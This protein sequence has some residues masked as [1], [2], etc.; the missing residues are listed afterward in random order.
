MSNWGPGVAAFADSVVLAAVHQFQ[1][2]AASR[3]D[4]LCRS[5]VD[6][7]AA[8][9]LGKGAD[10][11]V[12]HVLAAITVVARHGFNHILA[13]LLQWRTSALAGP[14][15]DVLP[16]RRA[17]A[18]DFIFARA[19]LMV[20]D[21]M[22]LDTALLDNDSDVELTDHIVAHPIDNVS[23]LVDLLLS[24]LHFCGVFFDTPPV[25]TAEVEEAQLAV[26]FA[27]LIGK[28]SAWRE[29]EI[30]TKV[31]SIPGPS[32]AL[33]AGIRFIRLDV[34]TAA[35]LQRTRAFLLDFASAA[36]ASDDT[37]LAS[38]T[39][40]ALVDLVSPLPACIDRGAALR[41]DSSGLDE[42]TIAF[43]PVLAS[44]AAAPAVPGTPA[45]V[46]ASRA[47]AASVQVLAVSSPQLFMDKV[48]LLIA[49]LAA[50]ARQRTSAASAL[51]G[52]AQLAWLSTALDALLEALLD[53]RVH[54]VVDDASHG[55]P[56]SDAVTLLV[57]L[58][59]ARRDWLLGSVLGETLLAPSASP[60]HALVG[61][62]TLRALL[63]PKSP[64]LG[65][66]YPSDRAAS[67]SATE[68]VT[69]VGTLAATTR[70]PTYPSLV[71]AQD[72]DAL[73]WL[74]ST[75]AAALDS[76]S[77][78]TSSPAYLLALLDALPPLLTH[79]PELIASVPQLP[80]FVISLLDAPTSAVAV[81]A[82]DM[83]ASL[84]E[85]QPSLR[86]PIFAAL[87]AAAD[88]SLVLDR[89]LPPAS[90]I[91]A[92]GASVAAWLRGLAEEATW[93]FDCPNSG[94]H[95]SDDSFEAAR[96]HARMD[97]HTPEALG[98]LLLCSPIA[99]NR[100][101]GLDMLHA[102]RELHNALFASFDN[103]LSDDDGPAGNLFGAASMKM[104]F[105]DVIDEL[106]SVLVARA[107]PAAPAAAPAAVPLS[108]PSVALSS[109]SVD[110][111]LNS[112]F[113]MPTEP[114]PSALGLSHFVLHGAGPA[115]AIHTTL[116]S[117][118]DA[119]LKRNTEGASLRSAAPATTFSHLIEARDS[120]AQAQWTL[121][122]GQLASTAVEL[123]PGLVDDIWAAIA[124][125]LPFVVAHL[126]SP[127]VGA[128]PASAAIVGL[129]RNFLMFAS[130]AGHAVPLVWA[131]GT[132]QPLLALEDTPFTDLS[133]APSFAIEPPSDVV[134]LLV[135]LTPLLT[136]RSPHVRLAV[137]V[138]L[139]SIHRASVDVLLSVLAE[140]EDAWR[141]LFA[142]LL[143]TKSELVNVAPD[144]SALASAELPAGI[145][146]FTATHACY[147]P[148]LAL[149]SK[150]AQVYVRLIANQGVAFFVASGAAGADAELD[151]LMANFADELDN[152][153]P[154]SP[155]QIG[156]KSSASRLSSFT[157][158]LLELLTLLRFEYSWELHMLRLAFCKLAGCAVQVEGVVE[159]GIGWGPTQRARVFQLAHEWVG[160]GDKYEEYMALVSPSVKV[161]LAARFASEDARSAARMR[162][163]A[164]M[165]ELSQAALHTQALML[166][167]PLLDLPEDSVVSWICE[168]LT[169][170]Y[171]AYHAAGELGL[172][173]LLTTNADD[174][175]VWHLAVRAAYS[176]IDDVASAFFARLAGMLQDAF[177][178]ADPEA[179]SAF[180]LAHD[181]APLVVLGLV[182][183]VAPVKHVRKL[184]ATFLKNLYGLLAD[185][186][187][188][189][190]D[191]GLDIVGVLTV[192]PT[193]HIQAA[194]Q[195]SA[196]FA[197]RLGNPL[198]QRM[199][200]GMLDAMEALGMKSRDVPLQAVLA[201]VLVPWLEL[202][203]ASLT[204]VFGGSAEAAAAVVDH[205]VHVSLL[206]TSSMDSMK[207]WAGLLG[208]GVN[209][210]ETRQ[211]DV[212]FFSVA[213]AVVAQAVAVAP[214]I[215]VDV[216]VAMIK[217]GW[218]IESPDMDELQLDAEEIG[219]LVA[220]ATLSLQLLKEVAL[221]VPDQLDG[222][223]A[224][225]LHAT[226][227]CGDHPEENVSK[228]A[229][230][231][232]CNLLYSKVVNVLRWVE[233]DDDEEAVARRE[234]A[235]D[236]IEH[237]QT[238]GSSQLWEYEDLSL[239]RRSLASTQQLSM[240]VEQ[241]VHVLNLTP[242]E[243]T[244][245]A[246]VS[247]KWA[248][249]CM[250]LHAAARSLQIFRALRPTV[251][252]DYV[253]DLTRIAGQHVASRASLKT[254]V[255]IEAIRT[256]GVVLD[257]ALCDGTGS[258][259]S[260]V[261]TGVWGMAL[262]LL[263]VESAEIF[264]EAVA[265]L[266][267]A[268]DAP[269]EVLS[270]V[271]NAVPSGRLPAMRPLMRRKKAKAKARAK[272]KAK[273][274]AKAKAKAKAHGM[275]GNEGLPP[276]LGGGS[277][278]IFDESVLDESGLGLEVDDGSE[279]GE[280]SSSNAAEA[281]TCRGEAG[282]GLGSDES[283]ADSFGLVDGEFV[284]IVPLLLRGIDSVVELEARRVMATGCKLA[285]VCMELGAPFLLGPSDESGVALTLG[286]LPLLV[287]GFEGEEAR[288]AEDE[289]RT[290]AAVG[291]A[292][293]LGQL[294]GEVWAEIHGESGYVLGQVLE[295]Y[296][297]REF[298]S[299]EG[300]MDHMWDA[301]LVVPTVR[302]G[303]NG[304]LAL[305]SHWTQHSVR[306]YTS[307]LLALL[308]RLLA[309]DRMET[310]VN[311]VNESGWN[312]L[313]PLVHS[314]PHTMTDEALRIMDVVLE[315][316]TLCS[317]E[318]GSE[319]AA[320]LPVVLS[321]R[322]PR[323]Q[324]VGRVLLAH[325]AR[326]QPDKGRRVFKSRLP[327]LCVHDGG[328]PGGETGS[329]GGEGDESL[330]ASL[331]LGGRDEL[332]LLVAD[333]Y[334]AGVS[335]DSSFFVEALSTVRGKPAQYGL[336]DAEVDVA[337]LSGAVAEAYQ[338]WGGL[339]CGQESELTRVLMVFVAASNVM[340]ALESEFS[341]RMDA[342]ERVAGSDEVAS[343]RLAF[344]KV[345][346][347]LFSNALF[348]APLAADASSL[349]A[350]AAALEARA[351]EEREAWMEA[352]WR[353]AAT[354]DDRVLAAAGW[355]E[356]THKV[357][358]VYTQ[359]C[360]LGELLPAEEHGPQV[361][362]IGARL[363]LAVG[364]E[365]HALVVALRASV[366]LQ[367]WAEA[368]VRTDDGAASLLE[369]QLDKIDQVVERNRVLVD[370]L[371]EAEAGRR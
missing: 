216:L 215:V 1:A 359:M 312:A 209:L 331:V 153:H 106:D 255:V 5:I 211:M 135:A 351:P 326:I 107:T 213:L 306:E 185:G 262:G 98:V 26:L 264:V 100:V 19:L 29:S 334:G 33:I 15:P 71:R 284:G 189:F 42:V 173:L 208:S 311:V 87:V 342:L 252:L 130:A 210:Y 282:Y 253:G 11:E 56:S 356:E 146:N 72:A 243:V 214:T 261:V 73:G 267:A 181:P 341:Q 177:P 362:A 161:T 345:A 164:A 332:D 52:L 232:L 368:V 336:K 222:H 60:Q 283:G 44:L 219:K 367:R 129:F 132:E 228:S 270:G 92:L 114:P 347:G 122:L 104:A 233:A 101:A 314:L 102:L 34:S 315:A 105:M 241:L 176:H 188:L 316:R 276:K 308:G 32:P 293:E 90:P 248:G 242:R 128:T 126:S 160:F 344:F 338:V 172:E 47:L 258:V 108:R 59:H 150:V 82:C 290:E 223:V 187:D 48:T 49:A 13:L 144:E 309:S 298:V 320:A 299:A 330:N 302:A 22:D 167:G 240:L 27:R 190:R 155:R 266:G 202:G 61:L 339:L 16:R 93:S 179:R 226:L 99:S 244:K 313:S 84:T 125:R 95:S 200:H 58:A 292:G 147:A 6:L 110:G 20:L 76:A 121:L 335:D 250:V 10:P 85:A 247:L 145:L 166:S 348:E 31:A 170:E 67:A 221:L 30:M 64:N 353:A 301:L 117:E 159:G 133:A 281:V 137:S 37:S 278:A 354:L 57:I 297:E 23:R 333:E 18:V 275:G 79:C 17:L 279:S 7:P 207:L 287:S 152:S 355:A 53:D 337:L 149:L 310:L 350:A 168:G 113:W 154:A 103:L 294:W 263:F 119:S 218:V 349:K 343:R 329:T 321:F 260:D 66:R 358:E 89:P 363:C 327:V 307:P 54:L 174:L 143:T 8:H 78:S 3:I 305:L 227:I 328:S 158:F 75:F 81:A 14:D 193:A 36:L 259:V 230:S 171:A 9:V 38:A 28:L 346:H 182:K 269:L 50:A 357:T 183:T 4:E 77:A 206:A 352:V 289:R 51:L 366:Q 192:L 277:F 371:K 196:Q 63:A 257:S 197:C 162:V 163:G 288:S 139:G 74:P 178:A 268:A 212:S 120:R 186:E 271:V 165:E 238:S 111:Q 138:S 115:P 286:A 224:L 45:G 25:V 324:E 41:D 317:T 239:S 94:G 131:H 280:S 246:R 364:E 203:G 62:L 39:C 21:A 304:A 88:A 274:R 295:A 199:I 365:Q 291:V 245:W 148:P 134:E 237:V 191:S 184:A 217:D 322:Y 360:S 40:L 235:L 118:A 285:R 91:Q 303:L 80:A 323:A 157:L 151:N 229:S 273:A 180:A 325:A 369:V 97:F 251:S 361:A 236:I 55:L 86:P 198:A 43:F 35:A 83:I 272:A 254:A 142:A 370:A 234:T 141:S 116:A 194:V 256:A 205:L 225:L 318:S 2:V 112:G 96:A 300:F 140:F 265:L 319:E 70:F 124:S 127:D 109:R 175:R 249:S 136:A 296:V 68:A 123:V 204:E 169:S 195:L 340:G 69:G 65:L 12:E 156:G 24:E 46:L 220:R 201:E 231:L